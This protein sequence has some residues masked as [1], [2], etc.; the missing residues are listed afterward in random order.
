MVEKEQHRRS[1]KLCSEARETFNEFLI[2][3]KAF[4][5]DQN[6]TI[7]D[8]SI[9][10]NYSW[11]TA[12]GLATLLLDGQIQVLGENY[13]LPTL[14]TEKR[15]N[16]MGNVRAMIDFSEQALRNFWDMILNGISQKENAGSTPIDKNDNSR[17]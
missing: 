3:V 2:A 7:G 10:A 4:Q 12:H 17:E 14:L 13:G 1:E 8:Y 5:D 11:A 16:I 15:P 9:L 6:V